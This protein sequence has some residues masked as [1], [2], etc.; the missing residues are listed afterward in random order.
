MSKKNGSS[1]F[2][3]WSDD[4]LEAATERPERVPTI[5]ESRERAR[6]RSFLESCLPVALVLFGALGAVLGLVLVVICA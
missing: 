6:G 1:P 3:W 5:D 4:E 2:F